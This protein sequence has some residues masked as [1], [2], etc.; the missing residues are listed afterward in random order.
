ME[1]FFNQNTMFNHI[2]EKI[3]RHLDQ[4][5]MNSCKIA[6]KTWKNFV[7]NCQENSKFWFESSILQAKKVPASIYLEWNQLINETKDTEHEENVRI[8]LKKLQ[9]VIST[10][11]RT[12]MKSEL[13][14]SP[15][16][17]ALQMEDSSTGTVGEI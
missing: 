13:L 7:E 6:C 8:L 5:T 4:R 10:K 12:N 2:G 11:D 1:L 16:H 17:M 9:N 14:P 15:L 3:L